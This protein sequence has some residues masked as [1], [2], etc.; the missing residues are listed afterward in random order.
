MYILLKERVENPGTGK[1]KGD[2]TGVMFIK[3]HTVRC[4]R[5]RYDGPDV[6]SRGE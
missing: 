1:P 2:P 4:W 6:A 3:P 5:S